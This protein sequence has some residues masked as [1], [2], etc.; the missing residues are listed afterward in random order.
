MPK[1]SNKFSGYVSASIAVDSA[2]FY[3]MCREYLRAFDAGDRERVNKAR[4]AF[5]SNIV[6]DKVGLSLSTTDD[7]YNVDDE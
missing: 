2:V 7:C 5:V 4:R 6:I 1:V 3:V